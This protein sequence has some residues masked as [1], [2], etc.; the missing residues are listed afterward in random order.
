MYEWNDAQ[1]RYNYDVNNYNIRR[2]LSLNNDVKN[3]DE[4]I[5]MERYLKFECR[6]QF[7][8]A[9]KRDDDATSSPFLN[10]PEKWVVTD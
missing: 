9:M 5:V 1:W 6:R 3:N 4:E 7:V 8:S 10:L 2:H